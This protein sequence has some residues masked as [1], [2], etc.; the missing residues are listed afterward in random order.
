[1]S[2][3]L[4]HDVGNRLVQV[5]LEPRSRLVTMPTTLRP[6]TTGSPEKLVRAL[7]AQTSAPTSTGA[8]SGSLTTP[9]LEALTLATS[10][11]CLGTANVLVDDA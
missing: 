3:R 9:A 6:S 5:R 7:Q 4:G 1:M 2:C 11:A 10:A 8:R